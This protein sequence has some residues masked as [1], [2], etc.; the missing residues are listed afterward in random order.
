MIKTIPWCTCG[1]KGAAA[2]CQGPNQACA[3]CGFRQVVREQRYKQIREE[4][5]AMK[6]NGL[7]GLILRKDDKY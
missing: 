6:D 1:P 5:L 4:G 3:A 7:K 2:R